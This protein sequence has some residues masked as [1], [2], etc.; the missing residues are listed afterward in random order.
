LDHFVL[1][2][3]QRVLGGSLTSTLFDVEA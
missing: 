2:V 1:D 3:A